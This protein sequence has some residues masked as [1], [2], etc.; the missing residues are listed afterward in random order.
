MDSVFD[1]V[2]LFGFFFVHFEVCN[3]INTSLPID[4]FPMLD[5]HILI[6]EVA[7]IDHKR[8]PRNPYM[9]FSPM[10]IVFNL[11][12][13]PEFLNRSNDSDGFSYLGLVGDAEIHIK[14]LMLE[15]SLR[16]GLLSSRDSVLPVNP[17]LVLLEP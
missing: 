15:V 13:Q 5:Q 10:K 1:F 11:L 16:F 14:R 9:T 6:L 3:P 2:L 4:N 12:P 7:T 8:L 17:C